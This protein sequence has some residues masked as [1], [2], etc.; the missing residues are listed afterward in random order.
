MNPQA[1]ARPSRA[2]PTPTRILRQ[3]SGWP[4]SALRRRV[5]PGSIEQLAGWESVVATV[6]VLAL[7]VGYFALR[8]DAPVVAGG[9]DG[10][11][12]A[13][14]GSTTG[15]PLVGSWIVDTTDDVGVDPPL[16]VTFGADGTVLASDAAGRTG[17]GAWAATGPDAAN[18]AYVAVDL[19]P[20]GAVE[21][22]TSIDGEVV[23]DP[24][25]DAWTGEFA[26]AQSF[27]DH[28]EASPDA[29]ISASRVI[30]RSIG[31]AAEEDGSPEAQ[32]TESAT[33]EP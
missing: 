27:A 33:P 20:D 22:T 25:G 26:R 2:R 17:H 4:G 6:V 14:E 19:D 13:I 30:V 7:A 23:V 24:S 12:A 32:E 15:H 16:L 5:G 10:T 8:R 3:R 28:D 21:A 11:P 1:P 18:F 9:S 29:S 31:P